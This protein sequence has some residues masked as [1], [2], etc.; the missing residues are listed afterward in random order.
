[1]QNTNSNNGFTLIEVLVAVIVLA[2]GMLGFASLQALT[3]KD[4][5]SAYHRSIATQLAYDIADRMRANRRAANSYPT[6]AATAHPA[7]T[8]TTG[9]TPATIAENDIYEWNQALLE[10]P[11]GSGTISPPAAGLYTVDIEWD[12][13]KKGVKAEY[14]HFTMSFGL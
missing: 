9:C 13:N 1:M 12:D 3:L 11:F 14:L 10:L 4:S 8:T 2:M 6:A 7:C 5:Q